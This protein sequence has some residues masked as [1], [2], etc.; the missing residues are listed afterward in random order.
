[1]LLLGESEMEMNGSRVSAPLTPGAGTSVQSKWRY[2][3]TEL[4]GL[5]TV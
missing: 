5:E 1:M 3:L 2:L 4:Y